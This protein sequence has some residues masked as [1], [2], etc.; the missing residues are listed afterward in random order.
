VSPIVDA[1][2]RARVRTLN[3]ANY[4]LLFSGISLEALTLLATAAAGA[5][6]ILMQRLKLVDLADSKTAKSASALLR[7]WERSSS[8]RGIFLVQSDS[9][10]HGCYHP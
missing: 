8:G 10:A 2:S 1:F 4:P 6:S 9:P 7:S 5:D 3:V